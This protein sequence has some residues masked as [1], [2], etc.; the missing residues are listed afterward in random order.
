M[1]SDGVKDTYD[2]Y[3]KRQYDF[4]SDLQQYLLE[5]VEFIDISKISPKKSSLIGNRQDTF[6][7]F[8][9]TDVLERV[10]GVKN[11]PHIHGGVPSCSDTPPIM[12]HGNKYIIDSYMQK[13][14]SARE[15]FV[16]WEESI[17]SAIAKFCASLYKDTDYYYIDI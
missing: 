15:E 9:Y 14:Q 3:W 1:P 6:M 12:G 8:N 11:V 13:A 4:S 10:Y 2:F 5:W 17:C 7:N 16:E